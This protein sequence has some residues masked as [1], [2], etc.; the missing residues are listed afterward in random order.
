[1][2]LYTIKE[3]MKAL[4]TQG[5]SPPLTACED[6]ELEQ[7]DVKMAFLHVLQKGTG[8]ARKILGME[9]VRDRGSRIR[10]V[11]G[12]Y[13]KSTERLSDFEVFEEAAYFALQKAVMERFGVKRTKH[14][15]VR[16]YF[17]R[18][19]IKS[20]VIEV[21]KIGT[22]DNADDAFTKVVPGLKFKYCIEILG[23]GIN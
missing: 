17:I 6:Y 15:N 8:P 4:E 21:A 1:M 23:V 2:W 20:K 9:V 22:K 7:L 16:Y 5:D 10:K 18:E 19:I 3:G 14:I 13:S 12:K 11:V